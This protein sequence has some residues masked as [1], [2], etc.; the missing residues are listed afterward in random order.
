MNQQDTVRGPVDVALISK[1]EGFMWVK[2][3]S[4]APT[5]A[6]QPQAGSSTK[7]GAIDR[8]ASPILIRAPNTTV[9]SEHS[10]LGRSNFAGRETSERC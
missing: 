5:L 8:N 3:K 6:D 9:K 2:R 4:V 7:D 10:S 1:G